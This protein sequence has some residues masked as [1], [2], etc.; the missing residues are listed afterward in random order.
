MKVWD[1]VLN[2]IK[3]LIPSCQASDITS[4]RKEIMFSTPEKISCALHKRFLPTFGAT[5][6][7]DVLGLASHLAHAVFYT[8]IYAQDFF[9]WW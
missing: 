2:V 7:Y 5:H 1:K 4:V 8:P 9:K 6:G 3:Y